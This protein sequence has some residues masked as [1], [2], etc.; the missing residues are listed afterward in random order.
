MDV[1]HAAQHRDNWGEGLGNLNRFLG[2]VGF[3][4][5]LLGGLGVA[6]AV[7]V[8]VKQRL[9]TVAVLRCMGAKSTRTFWIYLV[10]A[11]A[12]GI[13]GGL[14]G[15][16]LGVG[17]QLL[18]PRVVADFLPVDVDFGLSWPALIMGFGVGLG[19]TLLFALLP[20]LTVRKISP[21]R[22]LRSA[23]EEQHPRRDP[24]RWI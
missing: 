4:A 5:L 1:A 23:F 19:V 3:I 18:V 21:L 16:L 7:H 13:A 11:M 20:L 2:L 8:Y 14:A 9:E 6:S 24:F 15:C 10:Q 22:A 12:M 17:V